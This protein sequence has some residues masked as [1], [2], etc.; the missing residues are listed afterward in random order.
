M[1]EKVVNKTEGEEDV[2]ERMVDKIEE[3]DVMER[4][5]CWIER[6]GCV[7]EEVVCENEW[8]VAVLVIHTNGG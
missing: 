8:E 6:E 2:T 1:I 7:K 5:G 4:E 3:E